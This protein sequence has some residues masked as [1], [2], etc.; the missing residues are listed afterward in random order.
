MENP[1][2]SYKSI[3]KFHKDIAAAYVD[4]KGFHRFNFKEINTKMRSGVLAPCLALEAPSSELNSETNNVSNFNNREISFVIIDF[5]GRPDNFD[6]QEEVLDRMEV[7][8]LDV[9]AYFVEQNKNRESFLF[10]KFNINTVRIE[11]VGPIF[12]NMFGW[13]VIYTL[14]NHQPMKVNTEKWDWSTP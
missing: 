6:K 12:D 7:I 9:L 5:G 8:C 11:K 4:L 10:G 14:K 2:I 1:T 3:V 13:N